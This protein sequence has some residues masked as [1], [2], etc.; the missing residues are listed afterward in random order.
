MIRP[1]PNKPCG[2]CAEGKNNVAVLLPSALTESFEIVVARARELS[3]VQC[4]LTVLAC[5]GRT[6]SCVA[7][8]LRSTRLC[9]HCRKVRDTTL[10]RLGL[11]AA[12]SIDTLSHREAPVPPKIAEEIERGVTSTILTF[13]RRR[14][15]TSA[16]NGWRRI[17]LNRLAQQWTDYS[18]FVYRAVDA[19]LT[20]NPHSTIEFF[21]GR[22]VPTRAVQAAAVNRGSDYTVIE[23]TGAE[24]QMTLLRNER[25]HDREAQQTR[26]LEGVKQIP[27]NERDGTEFFKRRKD[28]KQTNHK[29]FT[30]H[31]E[32]GL[33]KRR[34][35]KMLAVFTSSLD[36]LEVAGEQWITP[37]SADPARFIRGLADT[38]PPDWEMVVRLHPNQCGD[39]TGET[40][41][42]ISK[43]DHCERTAIIRPAD[44]TSSYEILEAAEAVVTFG[45]TIGLEATY[46]G[47]PS[48]LAGRA[49]WDVMDIAYS[50][51][52][53]AD[54]TALLEAE[55]KPKSKEDAVKVAA[56]LMRG[57]GRPTE[58]SWSSRNGGRYMVAGYSALSDKRRS[59][60]YWVSRFFEK[61]IR[62]L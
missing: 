58:L 11:P 54:V 23:V 34:A 41:S 31:H 45:S 53:P 18:L 12:T 4:A 9:S 19:W 50:V 30:H 15:H 5:D 59:L 8:P 2:E 60:A 57:S 42:L 17:W 16:A 43:I 47:K 51:E 46:W 27:G 1:V 20:R 39:K 35:T 21:N 29:S 7:N 40:E 32:L 52:K 44:P 22:I 14:P 62:K 26:L 24:R 48:L 33:Y 55:I 10:A 38:L 61:A 3:K 37:A 13:Y 36:E 49:V 6:P 28:G 56:Y 25:I